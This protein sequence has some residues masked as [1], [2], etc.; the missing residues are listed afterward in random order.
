MIEKIT[1]NELKESL[2]QSFDDI[3]AIIKAMGNQNRLKILI[4]LLS[5]E[6]SFQTLMSETNLQKTAL[7]NHLTLLFKNSLIEKPDYGKY[8][9]T[10]DGVEFI[11]AIQAVYYQSDTQ[12]K[13]ELE[14]IQGRKLSE[15]FLESFFKRK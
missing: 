2:E 11:R 10:Q 1:P 13:K 5:G 8:K 12:R 3:L 15:T 4:T 9:I 14:I 6:K 7:S